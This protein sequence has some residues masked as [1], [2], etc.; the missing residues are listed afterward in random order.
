MQA[1]CI[2]YYR[3]E[4]EL[5]IKHFMC[6]THHVFVQRLRQQLQ[7]K[8]IFLMAHHAPSASLRL[9]QQLIPVLASSRLHWANN[10][11]SFAR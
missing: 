5:L 10:I 7:K 9:T 2:A 3:V 4:V 1:S 8:H 6:L 11:L